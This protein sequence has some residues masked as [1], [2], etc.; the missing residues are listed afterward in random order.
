MSWG[1][2]AVSQDLLIL[3]GINHHLSETYFWYWLLVK[4]KAS[5]LMRQPV[6]HE[7]HCNTQTITFE[8]KILGT[9]TLW[10]TNYGQK[11]VSVCWFGGFGIRRQDTGKFCLWM[12]ARCLC[13][14]CYLEGC[15]VTGR[16]DLT[17]IQSISDMCVI[18]FS[19]TCYSRWRDNTAVFAPAW[20]LDPFEM[21][22][23]A[24]IV[25]IAIPFPCILNHN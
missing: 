9:S 21:L 20:F 4:H 18:M 17:Q 23:N 5:Y 6:Y 10:V 7:L 2:R 25:T 16:D 14:V 22:M 24:S 11:L 19:D 13:D 1:E 15:L 12:S 3:E 8:E